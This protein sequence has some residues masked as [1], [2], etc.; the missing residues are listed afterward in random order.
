[1]KHGI[2]SRPGWAVFKIFFWSG[3]M[4]VFHTIRI[5]R[6]VVGKGMNAI[7][8]RKG[9]VWDLDLRESIDFWIYL[10]GAFQH[11]TVNAVVRLIRP[12]DTVLDIGA[13]IG[14][15]ALFAARAV[16]PNGRVICFEPTQMA[17]RKLL[18]NLDLNPELKKRVE[19]RQIELVDS[20]GQAPSSLNYAS[21]PIQAAS[22]RHAGHHGVAAESS[23]ASADTLDEFCRKEGIERVDVVK[24]DVDGNECGVLR[25]G[26]RILQQFRPRMVLELQPCVFGQAAP[27]RFEDFISTLREL[28]YELQ[29]EVS[30]EALPVDPAGLRALIPLDKAI[31]AIASPMKHPTALAGNVA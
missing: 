19:V 23:G 5:G 1:M 26:R 7:V 27:N 14:A 31:N 16:G 8:R 25:G 15:M 13:N 9:I 2:D 22:G 24:L 28:G 17:K 12:G 18:R 20:P 30:G 29:D 4:V 10:T 11:S 6:A 3:F 21:W